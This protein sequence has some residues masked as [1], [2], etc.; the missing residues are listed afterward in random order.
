MGFQAVN[1][2]VNTSRWNVSVNYCT[3]DFPEI[4]PHVS[5]EPADWGQFHL[6]SPQIALLS[7]PRPVSQKM[8][9]QHPRLSGRSGW[10][11]V[12]PPPLA[13]VESRKVGHNEACQTREVRRG[14]KARVPLGAWEAESPWP[15]KR[16][17]WQWRSR[18]TQWDQGNIGQVGY[19]QYCTEASSAPLIIWWWMAL[20]GAL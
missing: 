10:G 15:L 3:S 16:L 13:R 11:R 2:F 9:N 19:Y 17:P 8:T 4:F 14:G 6:I 12:P 1:C 18:S 5:S 7:R 20:I